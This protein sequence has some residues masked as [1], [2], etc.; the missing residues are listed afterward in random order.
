MQSYVDAP[1]RLG[2]AK[3]AARRYAESHLDWTRNSR[4]LPGIFAKMKPVASKQKSEA[5]RLARAFESERARRTPRYWIS[6]HFPEIAKA[7]RSGVRAV[8]RRI[9]RSNT[10]AG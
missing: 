2:D 3:N 1:E 9:E 10:H 6:Y 4:D 5:L 8:R 7:A